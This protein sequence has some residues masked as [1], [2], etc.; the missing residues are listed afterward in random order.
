MKDFNSL[1]NKI[2]SNSI[3]KSMYIISKNPLLAKIMR[4]NYETIMGSIRVE[5]HIIKIDKTIKQPR[6]CPYCYSN[7]TTVIHHMYRCP[8]AE[9]MWHTV[10]AFI[11]ALCGISIDPDD[12]VMF[13][14]VFPQKL[15]QT[16]SK[17]V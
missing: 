5:K 16:L 14:A 7:I 12:K 9:W 6:P 2:N 3:H 1:P 17:N 4:T 10:R 8:L 11:S 15:W 13:Q